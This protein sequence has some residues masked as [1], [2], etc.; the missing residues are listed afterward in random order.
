MSSLETMENAT[1]LDKVIA[2]LG[3]KLSVVFLFIVA[4]TFFEVFVRYVLNSP[5]FW[6]HELAI[7]LGGILFVFGGAYALATNKHVRV[8]L[9]YDN[10]SQKTRHYLNC[11][12]HIMGIIFSSSLAFAGFKMAK[13]AWFTPWG[14]LQLERSGT[15]W[16]MP[17]PAILK[18]LIFV[19]M[20][21]LTVQFFLKLILEIRQMKEEKNV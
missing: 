1:R 15:A 10:V 13:E 4:I 14:M 2:Y 19:I 5:T 6:V 8:V 18:G 7:F 16:N 3:E 21:L 17:F 9:L 12:H 11:F 20:V